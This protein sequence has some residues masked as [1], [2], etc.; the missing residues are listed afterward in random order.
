MPTRGELMDTR[1]WMWGRPRLDP[2]PPAR[3]DGPSYAVTFLDRTTRGYGAPRPAQMDCLPQVFTR[4]EPQ[5]LAGYLKRTW[6]LTFGS[7]GPVY[8]EQ[9]PAPFVPTAYKPGGG[10]R[11]S[12]KGPKVDPDLEPREEEWA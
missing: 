5:E 8:R 9:K 7:A 6:V 4:L 3:D 2:P 1:G 11:H 12:K 10:I